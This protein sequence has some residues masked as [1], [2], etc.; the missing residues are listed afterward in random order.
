[1][2]SAVDLDEVGVPKSIAMNLTYPERPIFG[3]WGM[4]LTN[5]RNCPIQ[6]RIFAG[7]GAEWTSVRSRSKLCHVQHGAKRLAWSSVRSLGSRGRSPLHKPTSLSWVSIGKSTLRDTFLDLSQVQ[8][9]F[10]VSTRVGRCCFI[11]C[12]NRT[13]TFME[14]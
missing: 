14:L 11:T 7:T 4:R 8:N 10:I 9:I 3:I 12:N 2:V 13:E 1:M 6:Y 5:E